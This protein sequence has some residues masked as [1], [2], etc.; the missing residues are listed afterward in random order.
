MAHVDR[1]AWDVV[2]VGA[3]GAGLRA[4]IEAR[5]AGMRTAVICKSL[6]GKAHTVMAE[7]GIA[8]SMGNANEHDNWQVHFRDTMRGGKFLNQWRMAELHAREAP[9]RV[10]E[11]ETWGALFDRT[12]DGRISQR[13]FGGH[14]YPRLAHVGDRTGLELI[15]TLQQKIV[16]LQQ[17][18][19]REFG[20]YDARLKVF[21]ECTVTRVLTESAGGS[22]AGSGRVCGAFCYERESGRF[23]VLEAPAVV[24]AT[25]GIGKSFKVTSNSWEYTGDGHALALLAGA[26]LIN[27]EFVQFHPT[28]MVWPPSV[29]GILVTESVRGDGG[30][31]RN[32]EGKRFMFDYIPDVFKDKYAQTEEEGDR[33]Y[34]DPDHNRRPPELLPRDEVARAINAEV[35]AGRGSPH[36]GVYLDV[37]TRM[38]AE[39]IKRRLPSMHH[40]FKELADVDI[41]A[42]PMEV[43][44][45]CHYVMGGV[46]VDPD[47]TAATGVPGLFAAGEVAGGM[48]GSNRLG[49]N[50]L[51]D[52]LV[53]GRRAGLH[54][55]EYAQSLAERPAVDPLQIDAAEAEALR[56]FSAELVEADTGLEP[57]PAENPYTLHQELQ[58]SMN[59]LVG[60]IRRESEMFEALKRLADLRV[61]ARRAGVEGHRQYNPGWHL[62]IDLR[63]MLLVSECVARAALE[64]EE[65][66]GGH[67]RD[68]HPAMD[69]TWRNINLVCELADPQ[70][71][72]RASDAALGQ[73][74]LSRRETPPIR[75][76][77]LELFEKDELAK[78]LTD[79]EL[80]R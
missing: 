79:E 36:G 60:I 16:S 77:L 42:E 9:D 53:F 54:A 18:D 62:A 37:S 29:K 56:P 49:G 12:A 65:S 68:D 40:Q 25:G 28:G 34:E 6:F 27:M 32:S 13:N 11:L 14:E 22:A 47:T 75:R 71:D 63:N 19:E 52:L 73:I 10:W 23:F 15:R 2:V 50:S 33:W 21:Q 17:E 45:T 44:P 76:D 57:G 41:T 74:R 7:G 80:S 26:P 67:T 3:G 20:A 1:Q 38:P 58:Q 69:R 55:A 51:S 59:D 31:L 78:Y 24:L 70:G 4:A 66:R 35:K 46:D 30:V 5:E 39:V 64:R 43:G 61:R 72:A 8:A 48:H